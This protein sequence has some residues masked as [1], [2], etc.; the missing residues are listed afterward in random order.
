MTATIV[1]QVGFL[2][3]VVLLQEGQLRSATSG[4]RVTDV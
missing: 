1:L 2:F 3:C 4:H